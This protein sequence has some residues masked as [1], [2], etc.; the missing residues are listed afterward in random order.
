MSHEPWFG[1]VSGGEAMAWGIQAATA[2]ESGQSAQLDW[3]GAAYY[4][5]VMAPARGSGETFEPGG[6]RREVVLAD[7]LLPAAKG[8]PVIP[9][10]G[11][12]AEEGQM[13]LAAHILG[14]HYQGPAR[15]SALLYTFR[16]RVIGGRTEA[17]VN[18]RFEAFVAS[19]PV[20]AASRGLWSVGP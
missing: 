17:E 18:S 4:T 11:V 16:M 5:S 1:S 20:D 9:S 14:S 13:A 3:I 12:T 10:L 8:G 2:A 15:G 19:L 7:R 6:F